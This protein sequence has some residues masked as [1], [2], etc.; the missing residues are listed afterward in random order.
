MKNAKGEAITIQRCLP[1]LLRF[2]N[3][4]DNNDQVMLLLVTIPSKWLVIPFDLGK[5]I[6]QEKSIIIGTRS[7][8]SSKLSKLAVNKNFSNDCCHRY[9]LHLIT[10]ETG[11]NKT[12]RNGFYCLEIML[13]A[14]LSPSLIKS[15]N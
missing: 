4:P 9:Y 15:K 6:Y 3:K 5:K 2:I 13:T 11:S 1:K 8:T 12:V 10:Y 14:Y 7:E